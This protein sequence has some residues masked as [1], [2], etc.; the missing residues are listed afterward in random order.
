MATL[1]GVTITIYSFGECNNCQYGHDDSFTAF[2]AVLHVPRLSDIRAYGTKGSLAAL[3]GE[4]V[5]YLNHD[6]TD[7][8][9]VYCQVK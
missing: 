9:S 4:V 1:R 3:N 2:Q 8:I 5:G 6:R 7:E